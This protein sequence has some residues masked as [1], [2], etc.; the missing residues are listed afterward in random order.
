MMKCS[1]QFSPMNICHHFYFRRYITLVAGDENDGHGKNNNND[2]D[3]GGSDDED[4]LGDNYHCQR[5][6]GREAGMAESNPGLWIPEEDTL[7]TVYMTISRAMMM[8]RVMITG[9][10]FFCEN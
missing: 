6:G 1:K 10:S 7:A 2:D 8:I 5:I 3:G 4:V 9:V